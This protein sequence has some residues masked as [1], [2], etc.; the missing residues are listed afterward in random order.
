[1]KPRSIEVEMMRFGGL[2]LVLFLA[3]PLS[4]QEK[5]GARD[6]SGL[7][8]QGETSD[9][10]PSVKTGGSQVFGDSRQDLVKPREK[11]GTGQ[12]VDQ[13]G[14]D[15]SGAAGTQLRSLMAQRN[16]LREQYN[17]LL[18]EVSELRA[19]VSVRRGVPG[20]QDAVN[21]EKMPGV[22]VI[23]DKAEGFPGAGSKG[24]RTGVVSPLIK[25]PVPG[26][27]GAG[28][29]G[30]QVVNP[31]GPRP[32]PASPMSGSAPAAPANPSGGNAVQ[33]MFQLPAAP[34]QG[35]APQ[36]QPQTAQP[37]QGQ[38]QQADLFKQF[39]QPPPK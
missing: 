36:R 26:V 5:S 9:R 21:L 27:T 24:P 4:A 28:G 31:Q 35:Q 25:V 29:F 22:K 32:G 34:Q 10:A 37:Q 13:G 33:F 11:T 30:F 17:S 7:K 6:L 18:R 23:G 8:G 39:L 3:S 14:L 19:T 16:A 15:P 2:I 20:Q 1:M 38:P 12:A